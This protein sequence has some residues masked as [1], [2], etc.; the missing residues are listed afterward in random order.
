MAR[1]NKS[2][3]AILG[4][5][6]IRSMSAYEIKQFISKSISHF[7]TEGEGQLYPTLK[8]LTDEHW[9]NYQE[10]IAQKGG[11]KKIYSITKT[12]ESALLSWLNKKADRPIYR[13][14]LLLKLF[15]GSSQT[16]DTN[17][18][19]LEEAM[20]DCVTMRDILLSIL[21]SLKNKNLSEKRLPY[22]EI[23][24]DY[25]I[26]ILNSEINWCQRSIKK[27]NAFKIK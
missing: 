15:F 1:V 23:S 25:G 4:C 3:F 16:A 11:T 18:S 10:E 19:L 26:E 2:Q 20:H 6:S 14:E 17:I 8:K 7:W 27:L 13:N 5:L 21:S 12:G 9:V 22:I 24:L